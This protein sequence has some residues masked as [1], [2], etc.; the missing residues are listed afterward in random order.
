MQ[1]T[2][3]ADTQIKPVPQKM[4]PNKDNDTHKP[5][6]RQMPGQRDPDYGDEAVA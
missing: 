1:R 4:L 3:P 5:I 6:K 2:Y